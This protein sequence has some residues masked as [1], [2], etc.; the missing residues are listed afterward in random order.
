MDL[1]EDTPYRHGDEHR[2]VDS[3]GTSGRFDRGSLDVRFE[4]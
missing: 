3:G 1:D 2:N 4:A